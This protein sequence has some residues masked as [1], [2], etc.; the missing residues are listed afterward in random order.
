MS[1][2]L[3]RLGLRCMWCLIHEW[4]PSAPVFSHSRP[5]SHPIHP[6]QNPHRIPIESSILFVYPHCS[7]SWTTF[8]TP[9]FIGVRAPGDP[10]SL[11]SLVL[12]EARFPTCCIVLA[13]LQSR[14][15][16]PS[17][18]KTLWRPGTSGH[19]A[20]VYLYQT[21]W[22]RTVHK[23][24]LGVGSSQLH[25][26]ATRVQRSQPVCLHKLS[27]C[28]LGGGQKWP[29]ECPFL[30]RI[31]WKLGLGLGYGSQRRTEFSWYLK[32]PLKSLW[33][34][35]EVEDAHGGGGNAVPGE[36]R[37]KRRRRV[38]GTLEMSSDPQ[39][40]FWVPRKHL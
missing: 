35:A 1:E 2:P 23:K 13:F 7:V 39:D 20:V 37:K 26:E 36:M 24:G 21:S 33:D 4:P 25:C 8:I 5:T 18:Q 27:A 29:K 15:R 19:K 14:L 3:K 40:R 9:S 12:I 28:Y 11:P 17:W 16:R 32:G 6:Q 30:P 38:R 22:V 31:T 34:G 10:R